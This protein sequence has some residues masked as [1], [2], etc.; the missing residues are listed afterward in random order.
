MDLGIPS[1]SSAV[2]HTSDSLSG[3]FDGVKMASNAVRALFCVERRSIVEGR[4][5]GRTKRELDQ[6]GL[7]LGA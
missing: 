4:N 6:D 5:Y 7:E 3:G 1:H 2:G